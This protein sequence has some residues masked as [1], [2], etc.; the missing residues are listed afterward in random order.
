MKWISKKKQK[1]NISRNKRRNK[2]TNK[3]IEKQSLNQISIK[4]RW[5]CVCVLFWSWLKKF[6]FVLPMI[7]FPK[8]LLH[9]ARVRLDAGAHTYICVRRT[10]LVCLYIRLYEQRESTIKYT[11]YSSYD[12]K[13]N[14]EKRENNSNSQQKLK[15]KSRQQKKNRT[16]QKKKT[17]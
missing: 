5:I 16:E 4:T 13:I 1:K 11:L 6:V 15:P 2:Q 3:K 9:Y 14:D 10:N 12:N 8:K 17:H 7:S